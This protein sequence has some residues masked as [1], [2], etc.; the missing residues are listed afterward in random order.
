MKTW[1]LQ[2]AKGKFSEVVKSAQ[3]KGPQ[4]ITVHGEPVAVL[5]SRRDYLKL[6]NPKPSFVELM[7]SSPLVGC[8]LGITREQTATRNIKL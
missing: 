4:N 2:E 7:R 3:S 5:I 8:D 6:I 1:Q